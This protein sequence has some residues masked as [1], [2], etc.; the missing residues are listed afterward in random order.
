MNHKPD[1]RSIVVS[2]CNGTGIPHASLNS[3]S[4]IEEFWDTLASFTP[5]SNGTLVLDQLVPAGGDFPR[6][7]AFNGLGE[8]VA[9]GLQSQHR[10]VIFERN[11]ASGRFGSILADITVQGEPVCLV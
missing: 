7:L 11:I 4:S 6:N 1:N 10:V 8:R 5:Q 3:T 2:N 9:V